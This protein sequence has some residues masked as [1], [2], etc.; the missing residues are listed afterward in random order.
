MGTKNQNS[1]T[2]ENSQTVEALQDEV[3][4]LRQRV[5]ELEQ[6]ATASQV[7][8]TKA[9]EAQQL[10][11]LI[12]DNLP[13]SIFWKDRDMV[14]QGCNQQFAQDAGVGSPAE[15][16]GKSDL[17]LEWKPEEA[18]AFRRDDERVMSGDTAEY[19]IIE[20]Q[21]QAD[22]AQ[23]WL[24]TNKIPLHDDAN[25]VVGI[26]G[27]Y[28][29]ITR[30]K[31]MEQDLRDSEERFRTLIE[32]LRV[33]ILIHQQGQFRYANPAAV[34]LTGYSPDEL[35]DLTFEQLIHPD[36][37]ALVQER[38]SRRYEGKL[39]PERYDVKI[40]RKNGE[41]RW[42]DINNRMIDFDRIKSIIV[43]AL[44]IT[45]HKHMEDV[46][47]SRERQFRTLIENIVVAT[48]IHRGDRFLYA[49][50]AAERL[51]GYQPH[52]FYGKNFLDIIHPEDRALVHA[53]AMARQRGEDAPNDYEVRVLNKHGDTLWVILSANQIEFEGQPA[54]VVTAFDVTERKRAEEERASWQEEI[55]HAQRAALRE[56][57]TPLMPLDDHLVALPIVGN[58]DTGRAQ[59]I[60]E[61][62]LN[63]VAEY[64]AS[65]AILDITGVPVIDT[66]VAN[67]LIHAAQAVRLLGAQVILTGIGPAMA[68]TLVSLGADLS[69]VVTLGTLQQGIRYAV[70][71]RHR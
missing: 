65:I 20:P 60:M 55:I 37:L 29:N 10:L 54:I 64:Q 63:G 15:I 57:S 58:I 49:N 24:D 71:S 66:Q 18:E 1:Q 19:H 45:E 26:L 44:D 11:Q 40:I 22:G 34:E 62:L 33:G 16:V 35:L 14:Y 38:A 46:L 50:G 17:E 68:Q 67:A 21:F 42:V 53:R 69:G 31:Q 47:R 70:R 61:T 52:E 48:W 13:L 9:S 39:V 28:E 51:F 56:L 30:R 12:I 43:T 27:T 2:S 4:R 23:A 36:Y 5:A 25:N 7:A 8:E 41:E 6:Q 59:Q 3:S 32:S